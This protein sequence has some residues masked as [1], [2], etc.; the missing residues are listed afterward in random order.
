M[1]GQELMDIG[2]AKI[3]ILG[4]TGKEGGGLALRW[5]SKG[6]RVIIGSRSIERAQ[7]AVEQFRGVDHSGMA[8]VVRRPLHRMVDDLAAFRP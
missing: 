3:A 5:A 8:S 1:I 2:T 7:A 6:H 4:G